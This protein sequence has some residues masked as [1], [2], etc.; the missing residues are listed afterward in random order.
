MPSWAAQQ[1]SLF[2]TLVLVHANEFEARALTFWHTLALTLFVA[3]GSYSYVHF[4][5]NSVE[6]VGAEGAAPNPCAR[7]A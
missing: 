7:I 6:Q 1:L 3:L 2:A 5:M 4:H